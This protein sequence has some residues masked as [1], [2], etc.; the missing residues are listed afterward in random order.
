MSTIA[1]PRDSSAAPGLRRLPSAS[2]TPTSSG[3]P[4]LEAARSAVTSPVNN[5]NPTAAAGTASATSTTAGAATA[6]AKRSNRA[7]LREYYNLRAAAAAAAATTTPRIEIPDSEVPA[8]DLDAADFNADEYVA[9]VVAESGLEDLLRLYAQVVGEVR[10]LDAEKKALVYDN[11]SKLITATE[12]IRKMRANMD[13]LNPM[14]STLDP[15]IAQIY[16]QASSI[17]EAA[18][19][20]VPAPDTE[21]GQKR[22]ADARRRRTKELAAE[23]LAMPSRLQALA[24]EGKME[25]ARRKWELPRKLLVSWKEKG[26]GGDDVQ[27]LIDEGDAIVR[28]K[29]EPPSARTS[30]ASR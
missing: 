7:A 20:S 26:V 5:A 25:E 19:A 28:P 11:Y 17:R 6:A 23:A 9:R 21:Q 15:A 30:T 14:A 18:R 1:S 2:G 3:R 4:S 12:T 13:P 8:S 27:A 22:E 10:A 29:R 16:S 24:R